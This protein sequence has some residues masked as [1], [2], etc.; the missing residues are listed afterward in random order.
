MG[1][2]LLL[3]ERRPELP[4]RYEAAHR[5][6]PGRVEQC[7]DGALEHRDEGKVGH[8][9]PAAV[10]RQGHAADHQHAERLAHQ[11]DS[12]A[13]PPVHERAG[14]QPEQ[15]PTGHRGR[16]DHAG[17]RGRACHRENDQGVRQSSQL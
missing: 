2:R 17:H 1:S 13:V 6:D 3:R 16:T 12:A 11:H 14:G 10:E 9:R 15:D 5:N 7:A 8:G 4:I